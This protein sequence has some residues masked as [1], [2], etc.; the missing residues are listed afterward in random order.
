[1]SFKQFY[2]DLDQAIDKNDIES[3]RR[4]LLKNLQL[5]LQPEEDLDVTQLLSRVLNC[6]NKEVIKLLVNFLKLVK[7]KPSTSFN[8]LLLT[9]INNGNLSVIELLLK[10]GAK[11]DYSKWH[12][13]SLGEKIFA[14][15]CHRKELLTL[16]LNHG[17]DAGIKNEKGRSL[18]HL[19][20]LSVEK[21][22]YAAV[23]VAEILINCGL[24]VNEADKSGWTPL[25]H[26][27]YKGNTILVLYLSEKGA[28]N[29]NKEKCLLFAVYHAK[30]DIVDMLMS[31]GVSVDARKMSFQRFHRD[32]R[33][34]LQKN[35][36]KLVRQIF[37]KNLELL[38][39]PKSRDVRCLMLA[40]AV[41]CEDEKIVK[42][43]ISFLK[44]VNF[45]ANENLEKHLEIAVSKGNARVTRLLL[46]KGVRLASPIQST[47]DSLAQLIFKRTNIGKRKEILLLLLNNGLNVKIKNEQGQ[48]LLHEFIYTFVKYNDEDA[49][50]VAEI[51][52]NCGLSINELNESGRS[53]VHYS[54]INNNI[55][56]VSFLINKGANIEDKSLLNLAVYYNHVSIVDLLLSS[57][58]D[59]NGA[60]FDGDTALHN[61]CSY[62]YEELICVL[63]RKGANINAVNTNNA[64]PFSQ[65]DEEDDDYESCLRVMVKEF[66]K[67]TFDNISVNKFDMD[68]VQANPMAQECLAEC[69][70]E[71]S[72]M[73][74]IKFYGPFTYYNILQMKKN[75]EKLACL[76]K[77]KEFVS[78]FEENLYE[79]SIYKDDLQRIFDEALQVKD[80]LEAKDL[81]LCYI[82]GDIFPDVVRR[83]LAKNLTI[84]DLPL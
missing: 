44:L 69:V 83:K 59:I 33:F 4:I 36:V 12:E 49:V 79:F 63:I 55:Q 31:R 50:E 32:L 66:S 61:A 48:T 26:A 7:I 76:T 35:N 58:A 8:D 72:L 2:D 17:L 29:A 45:G 37:L 18:L 41:N 15:S 13:N 81:R 23:E 42:L 40:E 30:E 51:L 5:L 3:I 57:G 39:N 6:Y 65:M 73:S 64:T 47:V 70:G 75:I 9:G 67:L 1:M 74:S 68:L 34:T 10:N 19:L 22:D 16:L 60:D 27:M 28:D 53:A 11:I 78:K 46:S 56:L 24:S 71:L 21:D 20:A 82:F 52:I 62:H 25:H 84:E 14:C 77:N 80:I 38:D 54:I 43:I